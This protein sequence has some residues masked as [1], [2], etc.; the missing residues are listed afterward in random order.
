MKRLIL[1]VLLIT[2]ACYGSQQS[3]CGS[4][5]TPVPPTPTP[6]AT[7]SPTATPTATPTPSP[8]PFV[9]ALP[10][11]TAAQC[12]PTTPLLETRVQGAQSTLTAGNSEAAYVASLVS[13][14]KATGVCATSGGGLP[15][16]EIAVKVSQT[17]SETYDV[18]NA[19]NFPQTLYIHTCTP[20][21]F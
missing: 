16:D 1:L 18:W 4:G 8:N 9:C 7:P 20:A 10:P 12:S 19:A 5:P 17:F 11:S 2:V 15:G 6:T 14:L 21:R 13:A 3:A